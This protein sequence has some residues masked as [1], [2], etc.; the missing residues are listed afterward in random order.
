M[1][2]FDRIRVMYFMYCL[3][4]RNGYAHGAFLK[5]HRAF[6]DMGED[7]F[8]SHIIFRQMQNILDSEIMLLLL[9]E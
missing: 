9:P 6:H 8:F 7:C 3:L 5:K 1:I 4:H 2:S